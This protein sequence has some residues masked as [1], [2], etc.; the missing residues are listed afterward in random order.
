[1][2]FYCQKLY[3]PQVFFFFSF[4]LLPFPSL[5]PNPLIIFP[6][7]PGGGIRNNIQA[8]MALNELKWVVMKFLLE[9]ITSHLNPFKSIQVHS[10]SFRPSKLVLN[11]PLNPYL[12]APPIQDTTIMTTKEKFHSSNVRR[13]SPAQKHVCRSSV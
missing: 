12:L 2:I 10:S 7:P 8:W 6:P 13:G 9:A 5:S 1:M 4:F 11:P 3:F